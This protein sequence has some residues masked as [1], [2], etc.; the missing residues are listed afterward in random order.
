MNRIGSIDKHIT[1]TMNVLVSVEKN[2]CACII[3]AHNMIDLAHI[4]TACFMI[5]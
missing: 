4:P 3:Y 2:I 1:G 5:L